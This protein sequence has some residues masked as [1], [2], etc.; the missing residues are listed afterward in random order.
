MDAFRYMAQGKH[1]GKIL[2]NRDDP[3]I[4]VKADRSY[5]ITGATGGLGMLFANWFA[6]HGAGEVILAARRDVRDVD[7]DGVKA[8]EAK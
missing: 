7:P 3:A 5:L 1:I 4:E 6:D 8:I 2:I